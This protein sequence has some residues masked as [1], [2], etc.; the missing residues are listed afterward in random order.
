MWYMFSIQCEES[1][2]NHFYSTSCGDSALRLLILVAGRL[3][4][5]TS[6]DVFIFN[7][8]SHFERSFWE[9]CIFKGPNRVQRALKT[10][11]LNTPTIT[12]FWLLWW[13]WKVRCTDVAFGTLNR[14]FI[15]INMIM[16]RAS[17]TT[18]SNWAWYPGYDKP[19]H[20]LCQSGRSRPGHR[21]SLSLSI[22]LS[23]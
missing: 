18:L 8:G 20:K 10:S 17:F 11:I 23:T 21:P 6:S 4:W 7:L 1:K 22:S 3:Y 19:G 5:G 9:R 14:S 15:H 2:I 16:S 12:K 13:S